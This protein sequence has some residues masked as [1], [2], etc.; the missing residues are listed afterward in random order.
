[1]AM[2]YVA[3]FDA[4]GE[5][6]GYPILSVGG[7]VAPIK[8]WARFE[9]EWLSALHAEGLKEFH[10]TDFATSGG[11]FTKWKGDKPRRSKFLAVLKNIIKRNTNKEFMATV[12]IDAWNEV[13]S[14]YFLEE[15][16]HSP[17]ALCGYTLVRQVLKWSASKRLKTPLKFIFEDGDDGWDG[18]VELC[19]RNGVVPIR[20]PKE[21]A[22]PCQV[23]D[24]IAWKNRIAATNALLKLNK[25][26]A[27]PYPDFENFKGILDDWESLE[28]VLVIP[29]NP[30][31]FG[32]EALIRT[33]NNSGII[34]RSALANL[35]LGV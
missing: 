32:R 34:K 1:M 17:Y 25:V 31:F 13:N 19:K 24:W 2:F 22:V 15:V 30:G 28:N 9:H 26:L 20:L 11:E 16:F 7:I 35:K 3:Y 4:S 8:K 14:E 6:S 12:E 18:L 29:G 21:H 23:A 5:P 10:Y 33:C 27:A